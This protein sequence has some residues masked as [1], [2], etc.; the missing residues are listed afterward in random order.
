MEMKF[1]AFKD[2]AVG[3]LLLK[4]THSEVI[5]ACA[6]MQIKSGVNYRDAKEQILKELE[7]LIDN[8]DIRKVEALRKIIPEAFPKK[9]AQVVYGEK[10]WIICF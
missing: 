9:E 4:A 5:D 2:K 1:S 3:Y 7:S 10:G 8:M 6:L